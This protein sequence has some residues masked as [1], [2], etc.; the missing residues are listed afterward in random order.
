MGESFAMLGI[1]MGFALGAR[2]IYLFYI[3]R[4]E[5][6]SIFGLGISWKITTL[7]LLFFIFVLLL[8][9][10]LTYVNILFDLV[11][12]KNSGDFN[13][14]V[15]ALFPNLSTAI[16]EEAFFRLLLFCSLV[17]LIKSKTLIVLLVSVLFS[18]FHLPECFLSFISYFLAGVVY[19]YSYVK[20]KNILIPVGLHF[21]WNFI[22][23]AVFGY[24][25]TA[26]ASNGFFELS[27]VPDLFF[28]GG[29]QGPEG[30]V[31]GIVIRMLIVLFIY[32]HPYSPENK[33]F[34][35]I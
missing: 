9:F 27:I 3:N 33:K 22:Q 29:H 26:N 16:L 25:V 20:F 34:L 19:G 30:S 24:P 8:F 23:G 32:L 2:G 4:S 6:K 35:E 17:K 12:I 28:N 31:A 14:L 11:Q 21:S 15:T 5:A 13:S 18:A 7:L 1:F 10:S